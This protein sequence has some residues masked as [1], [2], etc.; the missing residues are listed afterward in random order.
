MNGLMDGSKGQGLMYE[1][2]NGGGS[3]V[4]QLSR[5]TFKQI[6][7]HSIKDTLFS[8]HSERR[9][10]RILMGTEYRGLPPGS[11]L[12]IQYISGKSEIRI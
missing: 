2:M 1:G 4:D 9:D 8:C 11:L 12:E 5:C 10:S 3:L 6:H 7:F